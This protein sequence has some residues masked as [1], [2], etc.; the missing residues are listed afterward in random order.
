M[1]SASFPRFFLIIFLRYFFPRHLFPSLFPSF[2]PYGQRSGILS[3]SFPP[4]FLIIF[5]LIN[6]SVPFFSMSSVSSSF[7]LVFPWWSAFECVSVYFLGLILAFSSSFPHLFL[8]INA[9]VPSFH[10][11]SFLVLFRRFS[12]VTNVLVYFPHLFLLFFP[13]HLSPRLFPPFFRGGRRWGAFSASFPRVGAPR[14]PVQ[15]ES[16]CSCQSCGSENQ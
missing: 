9:P 12:L 1:F 6:A 4:R 2:F 16:I 10:V 14:F 3:A 7:S 15:L 11:I 5:L 8:F 13:R